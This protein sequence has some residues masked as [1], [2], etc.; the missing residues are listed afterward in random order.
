M[1]I[2]GTPVFF[3]L[4]TLIVFLSFLSCESD[5]KKPVILYKGPVEE[6]RDVRLLYSEGGLLR[7][8]M[9][10]PRQI[11]FIDGNRL[12]PD[13][14][15]VNFFDP[16]GTTIVTTLRADSGRYDN[17]QSIYIVKGN[18]R[19]VKIQEQETLYTDELNWNPTTRKVYTEKHIRS[20]NKL[21]G[22]VNEGEGMTTPQDFSHIVIKKPTASYYLQRKPDGSFTF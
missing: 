22:N 1:R 19:V 12:Y 2:L 15:N 13:T 20:I 3:R 18:V 4:L 9:K 11:R 8:E 14:I 7:V 10:S 21:T 17:R 16:G 5:K 6:V